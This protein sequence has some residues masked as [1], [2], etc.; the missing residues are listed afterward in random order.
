[1]LSVNIQPSCIYKLQDLTSLV[2]SLAQKSTIINRR[3]EAD[4]I[5]QARHAMQAAKLLVQGHHLLG[6]RRRVV[7]LFAVTC[8]YTS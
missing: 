4:Q 3:D 2:Q 6:M 1:M 5:H 7:A 8:F